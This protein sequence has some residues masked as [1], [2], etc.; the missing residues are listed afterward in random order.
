LGLEHR[1]Q[2]LPRRHAWAG[3]VGRALTERAVAILAGG[4]TVQM[5]AAE[6]VTDGLGAG[7]AGVVCLGDWVRRH[8]G[9]PVPIAKAIGSLCADGSDWRNRQRT[10]RPRCWSRY[11]SPVGS[12]RSFQARHVARA[13]GPVSKWAAQGQ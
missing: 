3:D 7:F 6:V 5:F 9:A 1:P 8:V 10:N 12:R 2:H 13:A 4:P 11:S